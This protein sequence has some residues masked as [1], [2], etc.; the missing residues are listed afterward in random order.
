ML[1]LNI[2]YLN[3]DNYDFTL[4]FCIF[5]SSQILFREGSDHDTPFSFQN[6]SEELRKIFNKELP[7]K[8]IVHGWLGS[9]ESII[10]RKT[11]T[12]KFRCYLEMI[13]I[14]TC[15]TIMESSFNDVFGSTIHT[16]KKSIWV[17]Y[18]FEERSAIFL[19]LISVLFFLL[20]LY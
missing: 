8:F 1:L 3:D 19:A 9:M 15:V 16:Q 20:I 10:V 5:F 13:I 12:S 11:G 4:F 17:K 2:F 14:Y 6:S 7:T 18:F